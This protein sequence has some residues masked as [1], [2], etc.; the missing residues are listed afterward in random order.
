MNTIKLCNCIITLVFSPSTLRILGPKDGMWTYCLLCSVS[1]CV[2]ECLFETVCM[3]GVQS[4]PIMLWSVWVCARVTRVAFI[5]FI[6]VKNV[7]F[8]SL[9]QTKYFNSYDLEHFWGCYLIVFFLFVFNYVFIQLFP[10][11]CLF[12]KY[13][14]NECIPKQSKMY[15]EASKNKAALD[16]VLRGAELASL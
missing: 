3:A 10:L 12:G 14:T 13:I 11:F 2:R 6:A 15:N 1:E 8:I 5:F 9:L 7:I 16:F 4:V